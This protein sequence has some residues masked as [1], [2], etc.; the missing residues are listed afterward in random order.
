MLKVSV[1]EI[2]VSLS[3]LLRPENYEQST[4]IKKKHLFVTETSFKPLLKTH[5]IFFPGQIPDRTFNK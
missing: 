5:Y 3:L 4:Q 2:K 1:V